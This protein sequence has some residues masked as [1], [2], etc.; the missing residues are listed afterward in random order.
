MTHWSIMYNWGFSLLTIIVPFPTL[1]I[2]N[3]LIHKGIRKPYKER[4][5]IISA[6]TIERSQQ[7]VD[8]KITLM[9]LTVVF[10]FTICS[11]HYLIVWIVVSISQGTNFWDITEPYFMCLSAIGNFTSILLSTV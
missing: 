4:F 9:L 5:G 11:A 10:V 1:L 2:L 7:K 3:L 8:K 6:T